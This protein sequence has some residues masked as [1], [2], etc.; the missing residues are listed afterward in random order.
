[1]GDLQVSPGHRYARQLLAA[2]PQ[3]ALYGACLEV[4]PGEIVA[5][6]GGSGSGKTTLGRAIVGL[7]P[8]SDGTILF[9]GKAIT[10]GSVGYWNYRLNCQMVFQD[11]S[12][13]LDP[14]MTV[15]RLIGEPLRH[16][17]GMDARRKR[18][19]VRTLLDEVGL[20]EAFAP[21]YP[22]ELSG[23]QRQQV[24]IARALVRR[25]RFVIADEPVSAL[26][27]TV[28]AQ[29]LALFSALQAEHGFSC[30]FIS[31]DLGVVE[32]IAD[33]VVVMN[34]GCIV[35]EGTRD[36]IFDAPRTAYTR[37]L[38]S[39]VPP[40]LAPADRGVRLW[41]FEAVS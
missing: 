39:A 4:A 26:D 5:V 19:R 17:S 21:R 13:S 9:D 16:I 38:L 41:R 34:D 20:G 32:Q 36:E 30:L 12:S 7:Q 35:E 18:D 10:Q 37:A 28:R 15:G 23:G 2:M 22:H 1:M 29:I 3:R 33:R 6:V 31:H 25:P 14:R 8:A 40:P 24:A 11:P 27:V